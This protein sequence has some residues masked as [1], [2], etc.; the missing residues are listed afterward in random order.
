MDTEYISLK[1]MI[2][3]IGSGLQ[4]E[5]QEIISP[6]NISMMKHCEVDV[7][8]GTDT[9]VESGDFNAKIVPTMKIKMESGNHYDK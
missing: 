1:A 7:L 4:Q 3:S 9:D 2:D 6:F 8:M 5:T